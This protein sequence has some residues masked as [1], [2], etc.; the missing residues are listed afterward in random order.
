M[1]QYIL[2]DSLHK[3]N[4]QRSPSAVYHIL[5]GKRSSQSI[6]DVHIFDLKSYFGIY[7]TLKR[8]AFQKCM[9]YLEYLELTD[10]SREGLVLTT[11]GI[12]FLEKS[13]VRQEAAQF[14]GLEYDRLAEPFSERLTLFIQLTSN[15]LSGEK[16]FIPITDNH[17]VQDWT[18]NF[19]LE[20]RADIKPFFNRLYQE[21]FEFLGTVSEEQASIFVDRLT[22]YNQ[23]GLSRQQIKDKHQ[24]TYHDVNIQITLTIHKLIHWINNHNDELILEKFISS[25]VQKP[26][27]TESAEKTLSLLLKGYNAELISK[28]RRLKMNTIYDHIIEIAYLDPEFDY[29]PYLTK[30]DFEEIAN[31]AGKIGDKKLKSLSEKL[32]KKFSYFQLRLVL[33]VNESKQ[34]SLR[35]GN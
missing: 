25:S 17:A 33:A 32:E 7:K 1:F 22:G 23:Y 13:E 18:K 16:N 9:E 29:S 21:L 24:L 30:N 15:V 34:G 31:A 3:L 12:T 26:L 27:N 10:S 2:L 5:T 6:Q 4:K 14:H 8:E 11:R 19:F 35:N 20:N 28:I